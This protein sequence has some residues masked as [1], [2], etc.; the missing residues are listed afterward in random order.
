MAK[1][2]KKHH[3]DAKKAYGQAKRAHGEVKK[4]HKAVKSAKVGTIKGEVRKTA[5]RA[6]MQI[7]CY[8]RTIYKIKIYS[9]FIWGIR[10]W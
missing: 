5:R 1:Q 2:A 6:Y 9:N 8:K 4:I 3:D 7:E 10:T